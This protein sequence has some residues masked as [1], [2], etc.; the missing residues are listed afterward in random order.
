MKSL[1]LAYIL[2]LLSWSFSKGQT[3]TIITSDIDNF[4]DAFDRLHNAKTK[5]DSVQ[6]IEVLYLGKA[7][8]GFKKLI[9]VRDLTAEKYIYQIGRYPEYWKSV[10]NN[11][12]SVAGYRSEIIN[13][14]DLYG[15]SLKNFKAPDICFAI[16]ILST[17][18]TVKGGW[19]LIGTEM[20]AS[21]S[22]T[23]RDGM[24]GWLKHTLPKKPMILEF[25]AHEIV[26][27]QQRIGP[28]VV[29]GHFRHRLLT[30]TIME[31]AADFI[32]KKVTGTSINDNMYTYAYENEEQIWN[33]FSQE[34]YGNDYSKWLYN[35]NN[36]K[37][38]PA[39]LGY[40]IGY[41]ICEAY[42]NQAADKE[43][44]LNEILKTNNFRK[45][46]NKSGYGEKF[47]SGKPD[48]SKKT[49]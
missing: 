39:D 13:Q 33:E 44:A 4:W 11:T 27:T 28:G 25:T 37:D 19:L 26:H 15:Q 46:L 10:R 38:R 20:V 48:L 14:M 31:G 17:G 35:G 29:W 3:P 36:S 40:F 41:R 12:L 22:A 32:A 5:K 43:K 42:Y 1:L 8:Q 2:L 45:F 23:V 34:M 7:S 47:K 30:M 9:K 49:F 16:G 6:I 24:N 21:D 18:G